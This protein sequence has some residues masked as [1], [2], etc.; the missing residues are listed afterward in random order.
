MLDTINWHLQKFR[1]HDFAS[2]DQ[3][4][5]RGVKSGDHIYIHG[6]LGN[7]GLCLLGRMT[8]D[9]IVDPI[10]AGIRLKIPPIFKRKEIAIPRNAT[11]V[12]IIPFEDILPTLMVYS[13]VNGNRMHKAK[14]IGKIVDQQQFRTIRWLTYESARRLD[15]LIADSMD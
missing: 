14:R 9:A 10:E 5:K 13:G 15:E 8:V 1:P 12:R 4:G 7:Y 3:Y 2:S 6:H 11:A